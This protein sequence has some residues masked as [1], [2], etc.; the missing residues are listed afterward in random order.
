MSIKQSELNQ[1]WYYRGAKVF[2][3]FTQAIV[4]IA[5]LTQSKGIVDV[6]MGFAVYSLILIGL[7]KIFLYIA[8]GG[9]E[10]ESTKKVAE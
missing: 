10:K 1:K 9:V 8:F 6:I 5:L 4:A 2:F 7:W 3:W